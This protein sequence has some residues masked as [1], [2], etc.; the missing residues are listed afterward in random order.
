MKKNIQT[1]LTLLAMAMIVLWFFITTNGLRIYG[2]VKLDENK[3]YTGI[4]VRD[5]IVSKRK[6]TVEI[7]LNDN[8][9]YGKLVGGSIFLI[10]VISLLINFK[11]PRKPLN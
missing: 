4:E 3:T 2:P 5:L 11:F 1:T 6:E 7:M 10:L 8:R 9:S